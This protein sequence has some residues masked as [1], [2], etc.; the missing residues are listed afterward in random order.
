MISAAIASAV[1]SKFK[2]D[3]ADPKGLPTQYDNRMS[4]QPEGD[5]KTWC[6][7][8]VLP[9]NSNQATAVNST[10]GGQMFRSS[11]VFV[12]QLFTSLDAGDE[13]I[14][15]LA[16]DVAKAFRATTHQ[17]VTFRTPSVS[18]VGR[19]GKWWQVNVTVPWYADSLKS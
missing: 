8:T 9:G 5:G 14:L 2:S 12:A 17:G 18:R 3:V 7:L 19:A 1:R 4:N 11:G 6:R 16:D 10:S 13:G 15:T